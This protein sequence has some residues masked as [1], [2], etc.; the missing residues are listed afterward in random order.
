M[1]T[2]LFASTAAFRPR[3]VAPL[4]ADAAGDPCPPAGWC[5]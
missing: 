2:N 3:I 1:H 4:G 5:V